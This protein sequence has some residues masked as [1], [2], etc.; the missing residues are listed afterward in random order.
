VAE[1]SVHLFPPNATGHDLKVTVA[2]NCDGMGA[3]EQAS[4]SDVKID[5]TRIVAP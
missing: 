4:V 5:V 1:R 3:A 2:D